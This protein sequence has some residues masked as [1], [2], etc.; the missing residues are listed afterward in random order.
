M[1]K[2]SAHTLGIAQGNDVIF[3]DFED[4]GEMWTGTGHREA[5]KEV[6]FREVFR[7]V[8]VVHCSLTM[9][10]VDAATNVRADVEAEEITKEGFELVFRTWGD[11]KIARVRI[12]WMAIGPVKNEDDWDLY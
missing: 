8:P 4:G 5:R 11:T 7:E 3:E 1:K 2:F 9:W 6:T 10:D 12:G